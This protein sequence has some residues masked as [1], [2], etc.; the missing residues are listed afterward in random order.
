MRETSGHNASSG[1]RNRLG[2]EKSPYLQQH[3]ENPVDW[4]PWGDEAFERARTEDRPIFLSIG[5]ST[6]HWCHVMER[7]S[8]EDED[9]ASLLNG[10]FVCIKVDREER[11]DIDGVYMDAAMLMSGRGGWPLTI[12]MTPEGAPFFAGT[13]LPRESRFG[14][15][16]MLE[17]LPRVAELWRTRR[18]EL[19][20]TSERVAA[21]LRAEGEAT[22]TADALEFD[23]DPSGSASGRTQLGTA[24]LNEGC[25]ALADSFD[26]RHGGFG[27]APKFPSPHNLLFLLRCHARTGD[28]R[29]LLMVTRTLTAMRRG[30]I[31]DHVG[32]GF[33]RYSTD[34]R[35]LV[36]HFEKMLYDQAL[37]LMAYTDAWRATGDPLFERTVRETAEYVLR[38]MTDP[39]GAFYSAEDADSEG[40]EGKFYVWTEDELRDALGADASAV[41]RRFG[42]R[43][44]GNFSDESTGEP[45]GA[46]ILH[47][48]GPPRQREEHGPAASGPHAESGLSWEQARLR[49]FKA[50]SLRVRPGRD[51][52]ILTDWNGLMIAALARAGC[53]LDAPGLTRAAESA[54]DHILCRARDQRGRLLHR[55][56]GGE[57]GLAGLADDYAFMAWGLLELYNASLEPAWLEAAVR[58]TEELIA[59]FWDDE[60]GGFF[61]TAHDGERLLVRQRKVHDGAIPS[62]NSVALSNLLRLA[63]LAGRSEFEMHAELI[64]RAFD[65]DVRSYPAAFTHLLSGLDRAVAPSPTV[66][67]VGVPDAEDTRAMISAARS[68]SLTETHVL[69]AHAD[70]SSTDRRLLEKLAPF[71]S[72]MGVREVCATA[73]VCRGRSCSD[74]VTDPEDVVRLIAD[75]DP[76]SDGTP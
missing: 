19:V 8:F 34:A 44:G 71:V 60:R 56:R 30:G 14:M 65:A 24:I 70:S 42:V 6:C 31:Y 68:A 58:L 43:P 29:Q 9:V 12:M 48:P 11:P 38:D 73:Y 76:A 21:A 64:L 59:R 1:R 39:S 62:A 36:P 5:Y 47:L 17:I 27:D 57:A 25:A 72:G 40:V 23:T 41:G 10:S 46:N 52:K 66:V 3:A 45:A 20:D 16:G 74:P 32:F 67:I 54:A 15:T 69:F 50:R 53:A 33:H 49:L 13:Y 75:P 28:E 51:D 18:A 7:E 2:D 22:S 26:D 4:Y 55:I 61:L 63:H 37:L 35:W